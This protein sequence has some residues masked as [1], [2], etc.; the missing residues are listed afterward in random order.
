MNNIGIRGTLVFLNTKTKERLN[1]PACALHMQRQVS[2]E[3]QKSFVIHAYFEHLD[4]CGEWEQVKRSVPV[5]SIA[6]A[7]VWI[8]VG[9]KIEDE[10]VRKAIEQEVSSLMSAN[11]MSGEPG[12]VSSAQKRM[13]RVRLNEWAHGWYTDLCFEPFSGLGN[14]AKKIMQLQ[15]QGAYNLEPSSQSLAWLQS[16]V[17]SI[18]Q[19]KAHTSASGSEFLTQEEV[20]PNVPSSEEAYLLE[21]Q[22]AYEPPADT[23]TRKVPQEGEVALAQRVFVSDPKMKGFDALIQWSAQKMG[24]G[25]LVRPAEKEEAQKEEAAIG[26]SD[27]LPA[28]NFQLLR[29]PLPSRDRINWNEALYALDQY[30]PKEM[31]NLLK[32][33]WK[34]TLKTPEG[35]SVNVYSI[36][37]LLALSAKGVEYQVNGRSAEE[38]QRSGV[39]EKKSIDPEKLSLAA[40]DEESSWSMSNAV[41]VHALG[42]YFERSLFRLI[43]PLEESAAPKSNTWRSCACGKLDE[44]VSGNLFYSKSDEGIYVKVPRFQADGYEIKKLHPSVLPAFENLLE[45]MHKNAQRLSTLGFSKLPNAFR[46][47]PAFLQALDNPKMQGTLEDRKRFYQKGEPPSGGAPRIAMKM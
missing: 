20:P 43:K 23:A 34:K 9:F 26:T 2:D 14:S 15:E 42:L 41:A 46:Q 35:K 7:Q 29:L 4:Q 16:A 3:S 31:F 18:R 13:T 39:G 6:Q 44:Q 40:M 25:A 28:L 19:S 30:V 24:G 10:K 45:K 21:P 33:H 36:D 37:A 5:G 38:R 22:D 47:G 27:A 17:E 32:G 11:A 8:P 1:V 12:V